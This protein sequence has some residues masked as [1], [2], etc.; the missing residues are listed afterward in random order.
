MKYINGQIV[1]KLEQFLTTKY[2]L[3]YVAAECFRGK[4]CMENTFQIYLF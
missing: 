2:P 1:P 4:D 3:E